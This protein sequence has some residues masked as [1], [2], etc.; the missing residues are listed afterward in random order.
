VKKQ[1][2]Q[3]QKDVIGLALNKKDPLSLPCGRRTA[4]QEGSTL[5]PLRKED[6]QEIL[7]LRLHIGCD[8]SMKER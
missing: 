8:Q 1:L 4:E 3:L 6:S 7:S 2:S 5:P